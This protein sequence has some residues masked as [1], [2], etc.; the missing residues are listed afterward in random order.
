MIE[1]GINKF[2]KVARAPN[3]DIPYSDNIEGLPCVYVKS[4]TGKEPTNIKT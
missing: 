1:I 2:E 4:N 3:D